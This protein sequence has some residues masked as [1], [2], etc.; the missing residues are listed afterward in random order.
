M[1]YRFKAVEKALNRELVPVKVGSTRIS[2]YFKQNVFD[3]ETMKSTLAADIYEQLTKTIDK[4]GKIESHVAE[5]V[6]SAMK[7]W[8]IAKG[9]THYTHWFQPLTGATAE[10][11]DSFFE[12]GSDGRAIEK[13]KGLPWF[14][15]SRMPLLSRVVEFVIPS[16]HAAILPGILLL[17][18]LL[19]ENGSAK[20]LCIPTVFV[21]YTGEALDYKTPLL[22]TLAFIEKAATAVCQ[23]ISIRMLRQ[24]KASLGIEQE[25]FLIDR[26]IYQSRPDLVAAGR[27]VFGHAPAKGQQLDDHYF[28]SIPTRVH[29]LYGRPGDGIA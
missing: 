11:H 28:G 3:Q 5:A 7:S 15:R 23:E 12:P 6:A 26:A 21:S 17:L 13:F 19:M 22:K 18:L 1:T 14:S 29:N 20:T 10:K 8:A 25:Y 16:K 27:T 4:G 9:A 2:E 24:V